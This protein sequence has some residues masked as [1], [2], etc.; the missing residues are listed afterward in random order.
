MIIRPELPSDIPAIREVHRAAFGWYAEARLVDDLRQGGFVQLSMVAEIDGEVIGHIL[1]SPLQILAKAGPVPALALAPLAVLPDQQGLGVG[2]ELIRRGLEACRDLGN[3]IVIV[4]GE[5]GFYGRFGFSATLA[6]DLQS[7]YSGDALMAVELTPG[8][9]NG[10]EGSVEYPEPFARVDGDPEADLG[11]A[12]AD[13]NSHD[14]NRRWQAA[15]RIGLLVASHPRQVW[16]LVHKWGR[17]DCADTRSAIATCVLEHLL[18]HHF[19]SVFPLVE[20]AARDDKRF[21]DTFRQPVLD[22]ITR[23]TDDSVRGPVAWRI[24]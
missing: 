2:S 3:K 15:L 11:D 22:R 18:E 24:G 5:P 12:D 19:D 4:L 17:S 21:A 6:R 9:L 8:A 14:E 16:E 7:I 10:V 1:F 13:L 23:L 20:A